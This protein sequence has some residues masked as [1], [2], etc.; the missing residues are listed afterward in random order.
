MRAQA[1]TPIARRRVRMSLGIGWVEI[2]GFSRDY[3]L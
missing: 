3:T 1:A 2:M